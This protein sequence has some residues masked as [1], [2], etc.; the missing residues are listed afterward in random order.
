MF[1]F[2]DRIISY[3][4]FACVGSWNLRGLPE[5]FIDNHLSL[6]KLSTHHCHPP[7]I[8]SHLSIKLSSRTKHDTRSSRIY[9]PSSKSHRSPSDSHTACLVTSLCY[10]AQLG[11]RLTIPAVLLR[12][13]DIHPRE[14]TPAGSTTPLDVSSGMAS[15]I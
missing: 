5:S 10:L 1:K 11:S 6:R 12:R 13:R 3:R 15:T 7:I 2:W 8:N 9:I 14:I 4:P